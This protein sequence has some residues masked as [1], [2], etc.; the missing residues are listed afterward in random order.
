MSLTF[1]TFFPSVATLYILVIT[2]GE[3]K[4]ITNKIKELTDRILIDKAKTGE[5]PEFWDGRTG[6][7]IVKIIAENL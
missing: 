7:R 1:G 5:T 4:Q 6:E 3:S 2:L